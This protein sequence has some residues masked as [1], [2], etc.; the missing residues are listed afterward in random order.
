MVLK[1]PSKIDTFLTLNRKLQGSLTFCSKSVGKTNISHFSNWE[2]LGNDP[3]SDFLS[4]ELPEFGVALP[5][6]F[7]KV[8]ATAVHLWP[9]DK[10]ETPGH[11]DI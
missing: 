3:R 5:A 8:G 11:F 6:R 4:R 2:L 7:C 9:L 10:A 1:T